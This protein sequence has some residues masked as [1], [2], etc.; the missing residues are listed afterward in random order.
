MTFAVLAI[1][2]LLVALILLQRSGA[3]TRTT[4][5]E[6][7]AT[8]ENVKRF[9]RPI[10]DVAV[11]VSLEMPTYGLGK[12]GKDL[13]AHVDA[14][15]QD[16]EICV[17]VGP[18]CDVFPKDDSPELR[19]VCPPFVGL[20][21]FKE[22]DDDVSLTVDENGAFP[23]EG[24]DLSF[25]WHAN[26]VRETIRWRA[27]SGVS[28]TA[29]GNRS[30]FVLIYD[31]KEDELTASASVR[32]GFERVEKTSQIEWVDDLVGAHLVVS[33]SQPN[34]A[35]DDPKLFRKI[36]KAQTLRL[37]VTIAGRMLDLGEPK[38]FPI[39]SSRDKERVFWFWKYRLKSEPG[40]LFRDRSEQ[41]AE[42]RE[43]FAHC[44][45]L[46]CG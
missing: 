11:S 15:R 6:L 45:L 18:T 43:N 37:V 42:R 9:S 19:T 10:E 22:W 20:A 27:N 32:A 39:P 3:T 17:Q 7:Q 29:E 16:R 5:G 23:L 25:H 24:Y 28:G 46:P 41:S 34:P 31:S 44:E 38:A 14:F 26:L 13:K 21:F 35:K 8:A 36:R 2:L 12:F 1:V 4:L 33:L 40:A 30:P